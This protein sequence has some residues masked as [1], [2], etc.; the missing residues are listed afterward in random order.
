[1]FRIN[2]KMCISKGT[3]YEM[4]VFWNEQG[5]DYLKKF[6]NCGQFETV[7]LNDTSLSSFTKGN[8]RL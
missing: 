7:E 8:G 4:Y 1:M 5:I 2:G 6:D 3:Y